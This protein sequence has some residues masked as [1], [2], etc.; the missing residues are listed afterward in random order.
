VA[1]RATETKEARMERAQSRVVGSTLREIVSKRIAQDRF[2]LPAMPVVALKCLELLRDEDARIRELAATIEKDPL[3]AA[4]LLRIV[5]SPLYGARTP[6]TSMENAIA[7][8]GLKPFK[9]ILI[10]L[11]A[12][13]VFAS[14]N[15]RIRDA[16]RGIWEHCLAVGMLARDLAVALKGGAD[17]EAAYLAGLFHDVGKPVSGAL[18]LEAERSLLQD[19]DVPFMTESLWIKVVG[20]THR[21]VGS[22]LASQWSLPTAAARA[23]A[24][25]EAYDEEGGRASCTNLVRFANALTKQIGIYVGE[26][27]AAAVAAVADDGRRLLGVDADVEARVT[28]ELRARVEATTAAAAPRAPDLGSRG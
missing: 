6:I 7:R 28:A 19:L 8:L 25:C 13:E 21:D 17:S 18:L 23:I 1:P 9:T 12:R 15:A 26:F 27:D 11:S 5:N 3:I 22:A 16:F 10:E 14:K 20:E 2:S 24:A 4:R